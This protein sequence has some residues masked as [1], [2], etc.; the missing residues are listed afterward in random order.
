MFIDQESSDLSGVN[1]FFKRRFLILCFF[2]PK[3][4]TDESDG[5]EDFYFNEIDLDEDDCNDSVFPAPL[6]LSPTP[7]KSHFD[8]VKSPWSEPGIETSPTGLYGN[9]PQ[10][11]RFNWDVQSIASLSYATTAAKATSG[12]TSPPARMQQHSSSH[13]SHRKVRGDS[14]K[15][16]KVYGMENRHLWCTQCRWKKACVRFAD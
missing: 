16:R 10:H 6:A 4:A 12:K 8:M 13:H 14:K 7:T 2:R 9:S 3:S 15:C 11:P 1:Y 5:E